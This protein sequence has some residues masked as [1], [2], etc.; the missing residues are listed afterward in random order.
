[1]FIHRRL[2]VQPPPPPLTPP[3]EIPITASWRNNP[4]IG[5]TATISFSFS[6][7]AST[8]VDRRFETRHRAPKIYINRSSNTLFSVHPLRSS[9][10]RC[11]LINVCSR[12]ADR[13]APGSIDNRNPIDRWGFRYVLNYIPT[14]PNPDFPPSP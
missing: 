11:L 3:R 13:S 2:E 10:S 9:R 6:L 5:F 7:I 1:M 4:S 12:I 8:P 14:H